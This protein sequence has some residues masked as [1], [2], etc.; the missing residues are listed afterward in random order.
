M[1]GYTEASQEI[2]KANIA[3]SNAKHALNN[4]GNLKKAKKDVI[5]AIKELEECTDSAAIA[6]KEKLEKIK[7]S[8]V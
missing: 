5:A 3:F 2:L 6:L 7:P 4:G 1:D 8:L